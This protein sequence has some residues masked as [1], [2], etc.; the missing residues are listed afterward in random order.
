MH[1][2]KAKTIR[3][4]GWSETKLTAYSKVKLIAKVI[5]FVV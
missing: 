4:N 2:A 3:P 1:L 5:H